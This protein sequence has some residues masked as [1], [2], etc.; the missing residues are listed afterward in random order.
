MNMDEY[1][2]TDEEQKR[3][4][5]Q[6]D[7]DVVR[8]VR[9]SDGMYLRQDNDIFSPD[10]LFS[11]NIMFTVTAGS[12]WNDEIDYVDF[13]LKK[14]EPQ[15]GEKRGVPDDIFNKLIQL[16]KAI[17]GSGKPMKIGNFEIRSR[18]SKVRVSGFSQEYV[19]FPVL[20]PSVANETVISVSFGVKGFAGDYVTEIYVDRDIIISVPMRSLDHI[21]TFLDAVR[22]VVMQ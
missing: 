6:N 22:K 4:N 21:D 9:L 12:G 13:H 8:F 20:D 3:A 19:D 17:S 11:E 2:I 5:E 18:Y 15:D 14:R 16:Y 1:R 10:A 7:P